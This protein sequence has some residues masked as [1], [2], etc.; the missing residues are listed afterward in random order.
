MIEDLASTNRTYQNEAELPPH[1]RGLLTSLDELQLGRMVFLYL[2][3][4]DLYEY[5]K[6]A[7]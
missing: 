6:G 7:Y 3:P 5:L 2:E 1:E 4:K